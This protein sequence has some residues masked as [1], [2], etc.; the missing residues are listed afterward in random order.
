MNNNNNKV[1]S[2]AI[3]SLFNVDISYDFYG[4]EVSFK[5][6]ELLPV[7]TLAEPIQVTLTGTVSKVAWDEPLAII[8]PLRQLTETRGY[9]KVAVK[10]VDGQW[11]MFG[12][13]RLVHYSDNGEWSSKAE[14]TTVHHINGITSDNRASN[15]K[16]ISSSENL[17]R[18][19]RGADNQDYIKTQEYKTE[20]I[21]QGTVPLIH[22]GKLIEGYTINTMGEV[23]H[24]RYIKG[25]NEWKNVKVNPRH[26]NKKYRMTLVLNVEH[27]SASLHNLMS[28][29]FLV[30]PEGKYK[31]LML[32]TSIANPYQP[33][34]LYT[35]PVKQFN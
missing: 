12:V 17:L 6:I 28:E 3:A 13:H 20:R 26:A 15:L 25:R 8:K 18:F 5:Y 22:K 31:T 14:K 2:T 33:Q 34:N 9:K 32:D 10:F 4:Q 23:Y 24:K 27:K 35:V 1:T 21:N 16:L 11:E 30:T 29:N 19:F 7:G